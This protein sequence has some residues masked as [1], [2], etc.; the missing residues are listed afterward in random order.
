VTVL[1]SDHGST[2]SSRPVPVTRIL[3]DA[4]LLALTDAGRAKAAAEDAVRA[5]AGAGPRALPSHRDLTIEEVDW[6]RTQAVP[7]GS[8][9]VYVNLAGR[10][11]RGVV[12]TADYRAVQE[13]VVDALQSYRDPAT[14]VCPFALVLRKEDARVLGLYGDRVGDVIYALRPEFG[15]QHGQ[16]LGTGAWPSGAG[17][18]RSLLLLAGPGIKR[19]WVLKRTVW[20]TDVVPTICALLGLPVPKQAEGACLHE[21]FD[22]EQ[23]ASPAHREAPAV[24]R[25]R[26]TPS[27]FS[28]S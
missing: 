28:K 21:A 15:E 19:G 7:L 1:V 2:P 12:A 6:P 9:S 20:L 16:A 27:A 17:A 10:D 24:S 11:P 5:E 26:R 14:G 22:D 23:P 18:L 8:V 25:R 3:A 13:R 4:G